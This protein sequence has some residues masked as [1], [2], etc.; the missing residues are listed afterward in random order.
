MRIG[1]LG[2][3]MVGQTI[4]SRLVELGHDVVMGSRAAGN[5][6]AVAWAERFPRGAAQ[7]SF[8]DAAAHGEL[9]VNATA[10]MSSVDALRA[11]G[12]DN[13]DGKVLLDVSNALDHSAGFPPRVALPDDGS[14]GEQIQREFP[15]ARVVKSLNTMNCQVMVDP[16][17]LKEPHDVFLAGDDPAA[18]GV[19]TG[20]LEG[21]GWPPDAVRD[22]GGIAAARGM[23][24]YIP[25]WLGLMQA[26]G[27]ADFNIHVAR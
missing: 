6:N 23:E 14:V 2:T 4:G 21:F 24:M 10:G 17:R 5:E 20:L 25:L 22:L 12:A 9:V 18:K 15:G 3:G 13:L 26:V 1:V 7:G 27:T 19:V 16:A 8:A 11:A